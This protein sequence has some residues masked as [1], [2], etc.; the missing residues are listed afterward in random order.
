MIWGFVYGAAAMAGTGLALTGAVP[1][2]RRQGLGASSPGL[3]GLA[4]VWSGR[5]GVFEKVLA[6][7]VGADVRLD[8][9]RRRCDAA[10]PR[11]SCSPAWSRASPTAR[12][13]TRSALAGGVGGTITLAA[14]GYWLREKGWD[15]PRYMR[16]MRIDNTRRLRRDR[17]LRAWR[18]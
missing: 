14:Y 7:L 12:S 8:G 17:H 11:P 9:R 4:L 1:G 16:V 18:R 15:T 6:A 2:A 5:Y 13:S 10:E 3:V